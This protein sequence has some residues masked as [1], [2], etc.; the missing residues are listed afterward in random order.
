MPL[1]GRSC[2]IQVPGRKG[3]LRSRSFE[4]PVKP[5]QRDLLAW[6]GWKHVGEAVWLGVLFGIWLELVY[7]SADY[8][9]ALRTSRIR[10]HFDWELAIPFVPVMTVFYT[11]I[12]PL[13]WLAP[14]ILRTRDELR[15][16][17]NSMS[18]VTLVAGIAFLLLPAQLAYQPEEVPVRWAWLYNLADRLNLHYNLAPSLHVALSVV[19]VDAYNHRALGTAKVLLWAWGTAIALS[20]VL[21]HQHHVLDVAS[22]FAL[23][24][25][26]SRWPYR[27]RVTIAPLPNSGLSVSDALARTSAAGES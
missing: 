8:V 5:F 27:R 24:I 18:L 7:S 16:L 10:V 11:S 26:I 4:L 2:D 14:F 21:T 19:C 22:G 9:T 1:A 3:V 13:F 12:F 23:A 20:T 6:P 15:A 17:V 25:V